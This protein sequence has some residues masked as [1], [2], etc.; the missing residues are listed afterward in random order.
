MEVIGHLAAFVVAASIGSPCHADIARDGLPEADRLRGCTPGAYVS[1][2]RAAACTSKDRPTL[3]AAD[4]REILR[5]YGVP[6]WSGRDGEL[7]H[8]VP[9]WLGGKT[10]PRNIWPEP[11]AIP[12]K[13]DRLE[14]YT[15]RRVCVAH[16]MRVRTARRIFTADWRVYYR[17]YRHRG[18]L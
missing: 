11:G 7:D 17:R 9:F 10:T 4:R 5:R 3:K 15:R 16:S 8:L 6:D 14:D 18:L 13:K 1:L 2:G 12:N